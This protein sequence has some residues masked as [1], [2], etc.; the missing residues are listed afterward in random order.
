MKPPSSPKKTNPIQTQFKP[1]FI[2]HSLG[3]GGT[4]PIPERPKMNENL[5]ATKVYE[6]KPR[7]NSAKTNPIYAIGIKPNL[8][9]SAVEVK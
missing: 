5:F 7:S 4:K 6:N 2:R 9:P 1:N 8:V 3:E